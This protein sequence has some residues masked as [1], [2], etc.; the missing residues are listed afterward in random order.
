MT[1]IN[2]HPE[3]LNE[4]KVLRRKSRSRQN[5]EVEAEIKIKEA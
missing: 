5:F 1:T 2:N 3:V 4:V